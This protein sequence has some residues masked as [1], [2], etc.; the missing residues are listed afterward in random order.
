MFAFSYVTDNVW[1]TT[2][3]PHPVSSAFVS[4]MMFSSFAECNPSLYD[5]PFQFL[6]LVMVLSHHLPEIDV[7]VNLLHLLSVDNH[8]ILVDMLVTHYF[9]LPQMH[10]KAHWLAG[11]MR[12]LENL[13]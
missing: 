10:L 7:S 6:Y 12:I 4:H 5:S 11:V 1:H 2:L 3:F 9:S 8:I 13:M